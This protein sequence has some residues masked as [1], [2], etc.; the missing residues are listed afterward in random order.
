MNI[1][2]IWKDDYPWDVRVEKICKSLIDDGHQVHLI[3][4]NLSRDKTRDEVDGIQVH[5]LYPIKNNLFNNIYSIVA[6]FN[7]VWLYKIFQ[8]VKQEL[9]DVILVRDLPLVISA[10]LV[11]KI[12]KIPVIFDMA[13]NYPSM[14]KEHVDKRGIKFI[15]HLLKNPTVATLMENYVL[16]RVDHT[17]VVVEESKDRLIK[18]GISEN[19]I[20][21]VSNTPDLTIFNEKSGMTDDHFSDKFKILYVGYID[22]GRGLDTAIKA[23][24]ILK[25]KLN[26][27]CLIIAGEGEYLEELKKI[28]N[29]L[30][31]KK[32]VI[33]LGWVD[34]K[35]VPSYIRSSDVCIVPHDATDFVN[36]TIPNK[37]FDYMACK[38]PVIVSD[39]APLR[40]IVNE[41]ECGMV[42]RSKDIEDF[43]E[44]VIQLK[45]L[46]VRTKKGMNG[47]AA[48][49]SKYNWRHDSQILREIF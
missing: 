42:F 31:I 39:A 47:F 49:N 9:I 6:F 27:F 45:D 18:K 26:N 23:I 7:P 44:K 22:G 24:P 14:W 1:A 3:C 40:R 21:I 2:K 10:L 36:S 11:S 15:N 29:N 33:F 46:S 13:E 19:K 16:K 20:S 37:L 30:G 41:A 32:Y 17:I 38:K 28:A 35:L 4:R 12:Y 5:R 34:S 8:V 43:A 48:I 25:E